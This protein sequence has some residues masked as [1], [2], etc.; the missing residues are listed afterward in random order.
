MSNI[1]G[2][3]NKIRNQYMS[4]NIISAREAK[5]IVKELAADGLT[6]EEKKALISIRSEFENGFSTSGL[7]AFDKALGKLGIDP[8]AS[9]STNSPNSNTSVLG[10]QLGRNMDNVPTEFKLTEV[11]DRKVRDALS[12]MDLNNDGKV[13]KRDQEILGLSDQQFRT[14][15]FG[16]LLL[17][18]SIK[19]GVKIPEDLSGKTICFTAVPDWGKMKNWAESMGATVTTKVTPD[20]DF[21]VVGD[22]SRTGKDERALAFNTLGEASIEVANLGSFMTSAHA[23]GVTGPPPTELSPTEF[24]DEM[25]STLKEFYTEYIKD[26]YAYEISDASSAAERKELR[27][28][29][30]SDLDAF[31]ADYIDGDEIMSDYIF[32]RYADNEPYLDRFG[33]PVPEDKIDVINFSFFTDLAGIGLSK[34]FVFDR[35]TG[36][37]LDEGD[38]N[39]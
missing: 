34:T 14:F 23:A 11:S 2:L 10:A 17:G 38:I 8:N 30:K 24:H 18:S 22:E 31:D 1:N 19:D 33:V 39:D 25:V 36:E 28:A 3:R 27:E 32:D 6:T 37:V 15:I 29:M 9:S 13:N 7:A 20:L 5:E 4:N 12:R 35:R 26:G 16:A 21:L